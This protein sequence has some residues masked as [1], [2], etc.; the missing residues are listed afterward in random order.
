[1]NLRNEYLNN[2]PV[3][4]I[5]I[6]GGTPS[7]IHEADLRSIINA[8]YQH[9]RVSENVEFTME[10]NPEQCT[11]DYLKNLKNIGVNRLSIGI[12]SLNNQILDYLGRKHTAE[13]AIDAVENA[14]KAGFDNISL[15]LI[16]G[17]PLRSTQQWIEELQKALKLPIQHLSAYALTIE[18]NSILIKR[19]QKEGTPFHYG[20]D[21]DEDLALRDFKTLLSIIEESPLNQYEISNFAIPG[22]ESIHNSNYWNGTPYLGLGPSAHS[23]NSHSRCWNKASIKQY[24]E[25]MNSSEPVLEC[26]ELS[27][28][29]RFNEAILLGLRTI[30]GINLTDIQKKF[31]EVLFHQ[32]LRNIEL[33]N[34]EWYQ[35]VQDRFSLS[36][37]GLF[38]ADFISEKLFVTE[39]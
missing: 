21:Q 39:D 15:D 24:I 31:G 2:S 17:I 35:L 33:L 8:I 38:L 18:E 27:N 7:L 10:A 29:N 25:T 23:F 13:M 28:I 19:F 22:F 1:M 5:Y 26:E 14:C 4:T 3:E 37:E 9:F 32:L 36:Q 30:K 20:K 12:Q 34:P 16:Y 11:S 6:G